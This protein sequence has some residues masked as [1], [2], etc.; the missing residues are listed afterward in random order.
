MIDFKNA[1][2]LKLKPNTLE[3]WRSQFPNRLPFVKIG[4][5]VKYRLEDLQAYISDNMN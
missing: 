2:Y 4:R 3:R 1:E 5:T